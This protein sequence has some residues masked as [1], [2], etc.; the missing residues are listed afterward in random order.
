MAKLQEVFAYLGYAP[1]LASDAIKTA[2][3][4]TSASV[5]DIFDSFTKK[6]E[7][8]NKGVHRPMSKNNFITYHQ[9]DIGSESP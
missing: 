3:E 2:K 4:K 6:T 7:E 5:K 8:K 1:K 9:T